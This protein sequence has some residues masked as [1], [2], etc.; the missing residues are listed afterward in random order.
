MASVLG[1][2]FV[3]YL[4]SLRRPIAI[5]IISVGVAI[6]SIHR[7]S[8]SAVSV[9]SCTILPI[10]KVFT[11]G[12]LGFAV[13]DRGADKA[14]PFLPPSCRVAQG[15][16]R[17]AETVADCLYLYRFGRRRHCGSRARHRPAAIDRDD[18][19]ADVIRHRRGQKHRQI[20]DVPRSA[21]AA[22][23]HR[24]NCRDNR[25]REGKGNKPKVGV[26]LDP[27]RRVR[28]RPRRS[29]LFR[30]ARGCG[31]RAWPRRAPRRRV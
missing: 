30:S 24:A 8:L 4:R 31:R 7:L 13:T 21:V 10:C 12:V 11:R 3:P 2:A 9:S 1:K 29:R 14:P 25:Q 15:V 28:R 26:G 16:C 18:C 27:S 20:G 6:W 19:A 22:Q 17:I 23:G 5:E